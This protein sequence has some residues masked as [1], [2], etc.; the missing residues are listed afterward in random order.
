MLIQAPSPRKH[1]EFQTVVRFFIEKVEHPQ[2]NAWE[3]L[4]DTE[5][6][7]TFWNVP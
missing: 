4:G 1:L 5:K 6:A 7:V 2:R 3:G